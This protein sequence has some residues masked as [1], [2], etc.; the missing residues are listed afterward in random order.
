MENQRRQR[1]YQPPSRNYRRGSASTTN[2][3]EN[4]GFQNLGGMLSDSLQETGQM[5]SDQRKESVKQK[6]LEEEKAGL[7]V[8][9]F[10]A[11][12]SDDMDLT[13]IPEEDKGIITEFSIN[14]KQI[15]ADAAEAASSMKAGSSEK[16]EQI[17]IMKK[18]N[19][20]LKNVESQYKSFGGMRDDYIKDFK[21]K[22]LSSANN[23][24]TMIQSAGIFTGAQQ[25]SFDEDGN[26]MFT[27]GEGNITRMSDIKQ[28]FE[29]AWKQGTTI[30]D[31]MMTLYSSGEK[32]DDATRPYL[33]NYFA[34]LIDNSGIEGLQS[35]AF[36]KIVGNE[37]FFNEE[38][39]FYLDSLD[40]DD[41]EAL[42][43][44]KK[45]VQE[46]LLNRMMDVAD[47][48]SNAGYNKK[49]SAVNQGQSKNEN[50]NWLTQNASFFNQ[51]KPGT[52]D[53]VIAA[54]KDNKMQ[55]AK[56]NPDKIASAL[57]EHV[58]GKGYAVRYNSVNKKFV[59]INSNA[60]EGFR[61]V[62]GESQDGVGEGYTYNELHEMMNYIDING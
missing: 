4:S 27:D 15:F 42:I 50:L 33:R 54:G 38:E 59:L 60:K 18:A 26:I 49:Q 9:G 45:D 47:N 24:D 20:R 39:K 52:V 23:S 7:M 62:R 5:I 44:A 3:Y 11:N 22:N 30:S 32:L 17:A 16:L 19:Q 37:S 35:L 46:L 2:A 12:M 53:D 43:Q 31:K 55:T 1:Q 25:R 51:F 61:N 40:T 58:S 28:P 10:M 13:A 34:N 21:S 36:D 48:R 29:K 56:G 41:P 8:E 6:K 57:N 14:Q